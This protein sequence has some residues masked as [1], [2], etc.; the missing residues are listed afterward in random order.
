MYRL[1]GALDDVCD[2]VDEAAGNIVELSAFDEVREPAIAQADV[3]LPCGAE[4]RRGGPAARGVQGLA[5]AQ[6]IEL[7]E[8]EDEGDRLARTASPSCSESERDPL[9]MIR[10]K[11]IHEGL[12]E[13][14]DACENAADVLEAIL[15]KNKLG[16]NDVLLVVVIVVALG[17]DFTNGFHDTANYVATCGRLAGAL[18][19]GGGAR[20]PPSRTSP[21]RS[22]RRRWRRP[23][24][25][26][27]S[28]RASRREQTMLAALIGAIAWNL[29][30]WWLGLPSSSSHALDRR[31]R[32]RRDRP[33]G[34]ARRAL[35]RT[36]AQ[37]R[38]FPALVAPDPAF[39]AAFVAPR[40]AALGV[41]R[42][43]IRAPANRGVPAGPDRL[44]RWVAFTHGANDAQKT[45]GVIALALV[46][47]RGGDVS[48]FTIPAWVKVSAGLAIGR[49]H[50][51]GRLA[52][53]PH[54]RPADLFDRC[55]RAGFAAQLD[56]GRDA[57]TSPR[58]TASRS[59]RRTS[60][61]AR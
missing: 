44:R 10:W 16:V 28:T 19:A 60:S 31:A 54:A 46:L 15:V 42:A 61:P 37:G 34:V 39:A 33:V 59:R 11:D 47:H 22:S 26:G 24:A 3:I 58:T 53:H 21:A 52:D 4:A 40:G 41:F 12:E 13:A 51:R 25:R 49:G 29:V 32:R 2:H 50:V 14:V 55:A 36:R 20:S 27:S 57:S 5:A 6:L 1:A 9:A 48:S 17:F 38:S 18:A 45:M 7:R 30:T 8:L 35:A 43:F 56:G 23:S